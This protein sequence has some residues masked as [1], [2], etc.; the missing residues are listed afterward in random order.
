MCTVDHGGQA[1]PGYLIKSAIES[2][3]PQG[4][5]FTRLLAHHREV[6]LSSSQ[7]EQLLD[8]SREYHEQENLLL[9]QFAVLTERLE[10][11]HG[12]VTDQVISEREELLDRH[13]AIFRRHER[14]FLE[15]ARRGHD[16]LSDEQIARADAVYEAEKASTLDLLHD[17]IER[18]VGPSHIFG[19]R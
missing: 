8:I 4:V 9:H 5:I 2:F 7:I 10:I 19:R 17:S 11:K 1:A 12:R 13:A 16:L 3:A 15:F 18:A 6:G 14:L